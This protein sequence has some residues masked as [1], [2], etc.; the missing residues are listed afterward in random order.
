MKRKTANRCK[1]CGRVLWNDSYDQ[2]YDCYQRNGG[3]QGPAFPGRTCADCGVITSGRYKYCWTC[4]KK[5]GLF[6]ENGEY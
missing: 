3:D 2:C 4:A 5:R 6:V 1:I